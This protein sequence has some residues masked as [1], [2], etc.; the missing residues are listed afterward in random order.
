[1]AAELH[2]GSAGALAA[3]GVAHTSGPP[4]LRAEALLG[5]EQARGMPQ[6]KGSALHMVRESF[7]ILLSTAILSEVSYQSLQYPGCQEI[8][9]VGG[10]SLRQVLSLS[11]LTDHISASVHWPRTNVPLCRA[12]AGRRVLSA[13]GKGQL[14]TTLM[15][16]AKVLLLLFIGGGVAEGTSGGSWQTSSSLRVT[17]G[18]LRDIFKLEISIN[19]SAFP[20]L[21]PTTES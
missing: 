14:R 6:R 12:L 8:F 20:L 21:P 15:A 16:P 4:A 19:I 10:I 3:E 18:S 17:A 1:M 11:A 9:L 2:R 7:L 5:G 13:G